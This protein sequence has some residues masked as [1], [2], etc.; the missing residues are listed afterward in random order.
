MCA[1]GATVCR[2]RQARGQ[3]LHP[4]DVP[5]HS[6][7][8]K[9]LFLRNKKGDVAGH[10]ARRASGRPA[11][12]R[13]AARR[14]PLSFASL[15]RLR[16]H[17]G[18]DAGSVTPPAARHDDARRAGGDR[19]D[20]RSCTRSPTTAR[21]R[22]RRATCCASS[23]RGATR[24]CFSTG[25]VWLCP[26]RLRSP[27]PSRKLSSPK[28][29]R[30]IRPGENRRRGF[31]DRSISGTGGTVG[32]GNVSSSWGARRLL[33]PL[34]SAARGLP[35]SAYV[36][37]AGQA[38]ALKLMADLLVTLQAPPPRRSRTAPRSTSRLPVTGSPQ[39]PP[40]RECSRCV[41]R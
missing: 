15:E 7:H 17:L 38:I 28:Q 5:C 31:L 32:R 40:A 2:P 14:G 24:R 18:V 34:V 30:C 16:R 26:R 4:I 3:P 20:V 8:V 39:A 22:W 11:G 6:A 13:W 23:R 37:R 10:G 9:N 1:C 21:R 12:A 41:T 27:S 19:H 25:K 29:R 35:R 36:G 33:R